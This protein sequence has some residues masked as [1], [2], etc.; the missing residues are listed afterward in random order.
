MNTILRWV[1]GVISILITIWAAHQLSDINTARHLP[2][3]TLIWTSA[4]GLILFVPLLAA[5]NAVIRPVIKLM[6]LPINCLTFGLFSF[7]I[8]ALLFWA[9]GHATGAK[10]NVWG[11]LFG[12]IVYAAI[13][14]ILSWPI[15]EKDG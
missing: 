11:A 13:S 5:I 1:V 15:K 14:T 3:I 2:P 12:S 9:A 6:A 8:G 7:V 10:M 4:W